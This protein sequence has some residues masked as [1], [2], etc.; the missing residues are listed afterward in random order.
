CCRR[1]ATICSSSTRV[2]ATSPPRSGWRSTSPT[3]A[4]T[5]ARSG[6]GS[7][8]EPKEEGKADGAGPQ[9]RRAGEGAAQD[10]VAQGA[11]LREALP[12]ARQAPAAAGRGGLEASLCRPQGDAAAAV[13]RYSA[14]LDPA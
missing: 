13:P 3:R 9:P 1:G 11:P 7:P 14:R 5:R 4:T 12:P 10:P 8:G 2:W 6:T